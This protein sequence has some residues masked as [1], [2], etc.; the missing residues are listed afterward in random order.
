VED[1]S[2]GEFP[3]KDPSTG[4]LADRLTRELP[5]VQQTAAAA[6]QR[7]SDKANSAKTLGFV[8]I[9]VGAVGI[10]VGAAALVTSRRRIATAAANSE[11]ATTATGRE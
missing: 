4:E 10:A 5:R 8:G 2:K 9:I 7:A 6:A 1:A 11:M 3:A